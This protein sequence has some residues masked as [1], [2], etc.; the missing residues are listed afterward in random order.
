VVVNAHANK[1]REGQRAIDRIRGAA[2]LRDAARCVLFFESRPEG[3]AVE[4]LKMNRAEKLEPFM[5]SREI[6]ST[7]ESRVVWTTARFVFQSSD[8]AVLSR[9]ETFILD[10]VTAFPGALKSVDLRK[11]GNDVGINYEAVAKALT[12]LQARGLI[13]FTKGPKNSKF[14]TAVPQLRIV[15]SATSSDSGSASGRLEQSA[16]P[17]HSALG[18]LE[19]PADTDR[20]PILSALPVGEAGRQD[21]LR[22]QAGD[23][24]DEPEVVDIPEE[25]DLGG[26]R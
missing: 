16:Q 10:Q 4:H 1:V 7:P 21:G 12:R 11:R 15:R 17:A 20:T 22:E 24:A 6:E 9:A 25:H 3:I 14:W 19:R 23:P 5:L 18:R 8:E 13:D 2:A 26:D